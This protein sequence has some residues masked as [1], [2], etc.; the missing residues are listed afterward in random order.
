MV[1]S[2]GCFGVR[3]PREVSPKSLISSHKIGLY[4]LGIKNYSTHVTLPLCMSNGTLKP[5]EVSSVSLMSS[6]E[7]ELYNLVIK[8]PVMHV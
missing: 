7:I 3:K 6:Q 5:R 1:K 8:N 4:N 2:N